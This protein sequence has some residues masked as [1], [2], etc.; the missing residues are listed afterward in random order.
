MKEEVY[1]HSTFQ[2]DGKKFKFKSENGEFTEVKLKIKYPDQFKV[3]KAYFKSDDTIKIDLKGLSG[4]TLAENLAKS[5]S[6]ITDNIDVDLIGSPS[7][8]PTIKIIFELT[9]VENCS[10][11]SL[12]PETAG[13]GILVGTGG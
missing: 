1:F 3:L 5:S 11:D 13:G 7:T 9:E 4:C 10:Q 8:A 6:S 2:V 12:V